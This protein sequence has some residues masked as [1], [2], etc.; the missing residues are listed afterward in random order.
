MVM[1]VMVATATAMGAG[2][3]TELGRRRREG[4][5]LAAAA[6]S[7]AAP[8]II[9]KILP[10]QSLKLVTRRSATLSVPRHID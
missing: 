7:A 3:T 8:G 6:M 2:M 10:F 1:M 9:A 5:V 4:T